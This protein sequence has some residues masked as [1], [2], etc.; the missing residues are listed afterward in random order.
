M[1]VVLGIIVGVF[2]FIL[3][4]V[5]SCTALVGGAVSSLD[6]TTKTSPGDSSSST[7]EEHPIKFSAT[8][9]GTTVDYLGDT[10]S[11]VEVTIKNES[12][13][14]TVTVYGLT[15]FSG[16]TAD[17]SVVALDT[18][19]VTLDNPMEMVDVGPG[20]TVTG[21]LAAKGD[22]DIAK[23]QWQNNFLSHD[24]EIAEVK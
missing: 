6:E 8:D 24:K 14:D 1:K 18:Y 12:D 10:Y 15:E 5:V 9:E 7:E 16:E 2:G 3:I 23:V 22:V 4:G 17:G 19:S 11:V 13:A 20:Q 21:Q